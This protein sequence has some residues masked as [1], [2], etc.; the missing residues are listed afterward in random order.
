MRYVDSY[1]SPTT[2]LLSTVGSPFAHPN[3]AYCPPEPRALYRYADKNRVRLLYLK[4][5]ERNNCLTPLV[6]EYKEL[7]RRYYESLEVMS[8]ISKA[9]E[10]TRANYAFFKTIRPY[11]EV[12]VDIDTLIFNG[13]AEANRALR[14]ANFTFLDSGPLST[15]FYEKQAKINVDVYNE[16]GVSHFVYLDKTRLESSIIPKTI[17]DDRPLNCLHPAADLLAIISH[18]IIKE[19]MYV[20]SEYYTTMCYIHQMSKGDMNNLLELAR[21]WKLQKALSTHLSISA[22]IHK[23]TYATLP[24]KLTRLLSEADFNLREAFRVMEKNIVTP[25]KYHPYTLIE[26]LAEKITETKA[27]RSIAAQIYH[28]MN[29]AFLHSVAKE[30]LRHIARKEY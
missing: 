3:R 15:T 8:R 24:K 30:T 17:L 29:P 19:Q 16:V 7:Q 20:L 2:T 21:E 23:K 10:K 12:T 26:V 4:S 18:S 22:V 1:N 27:R 25:Y 11:P 13:Y 28:T 14:Q 9:L 6:T 5:L